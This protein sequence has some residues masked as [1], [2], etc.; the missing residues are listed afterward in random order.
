MTKEEIQFIQNSIDSLKVHEITFKA[1]FIEMIRFMVSSGDCEEYLGFYTKIGNALQA[2]EN[3]SN[4]EKKQFL[5]I[6]KSI[7]DIY[8]R[9][10]KKQS[11]DKAREN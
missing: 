2:E 8:N 6:H 7:I 9:I 1:T 11:Y 4:E 5:I 10:N 3:V